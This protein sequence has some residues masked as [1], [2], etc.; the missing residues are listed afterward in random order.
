MK[1]QNLVEILR[2]HSIQH[3]DRLAYTFLTDD[4]TGKSTITYGELYL[5]ATAIAAALQKLEMAG[6]RALLL[7]PAGLEFIK[8]FL[9]CLAAGV[10]AVPINL[11]RRN[12]SMEKV[13]AI[14]KDAEAKLA[15]TPT[16][17]VSNWEKWQEQTP[18]LKNLHWLN[19]E[20]LAADS[21]EDLALSLEANSLAYLQYTSGSTSQPKGVMVSHGNIIHNSQCIQQ[22]FEL[23]P[24]SVSVSWLPHFHDMGLIDGI[25]QPLYTGFPGYLMSP[26]SFLQLPIRWLQ[27]ISQYRGTH[28]GGPNFAYD[29]CVDKITPEQLASLDLSS[30]CSAYSGAEPVRRDTL[31]RF[32][33]KFQDCGFQ[34]HFFYPCYGLAEATLMVSGGNL[35]DK[36][37]YRQVSAS[38]LERNLIVDAASDRSALLQGGN[39]TKDLVGCGKTRLDT[40]VAIVNPDTLTE[41]AS[42]EV[43]EIW[44]S[45]GS[46]TLGYWRRPSETEKSFG[47]TLNHKPF[48]RTGDL[49]FVQDG[50]IFITG[51]IK[52]I[53]IVRGRNHYPQD[54]ELTVEQSHP[55]LQPSAGAAFTVEVDGVEKLVVLQEVKR[56]Y[57]RRIDVAEAVGNI[58]QAITREHELQVHSI[59]LLKTQSI[60]KTSSGKIQRHAC[61]EQFLQG[62]LEILES[63][64]CQEIAV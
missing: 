47:A 52:D 25:I 60:P 10:V 6:E 3:P 37:V 19:S 17:S 40:E 13:E 54:I 61:K 49:G 58:R 21:A 64:D 14:A 59:V 28:G 55:G 16:S 15:L 53:A 1:H 24:D 12:R 57:L 7:Y 32:A 45:G 11:P 36:P 26:V 5:Q 43:G 33:A 50:E 63:G 41:C 46:V 18:E 23:T 38:D 39:R 22:A 56:T 44:I 62:R 8:A 4:S 34:P 27:A 20:T 30:W 51:R 48:F 29:L 9:G 2:S 31:E 35:A 42:K